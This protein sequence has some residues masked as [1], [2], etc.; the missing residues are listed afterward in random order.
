[1]LKPQRCDV[2]LGLV[3]LEIFQ[4]STI[5]NKGRYL[6]VKNISWVYAELHKQWSVLIFDFTVLVHDM[7]VAHLDLAIYD[8][9]L[10]FTYVFLCLVI[11]AHFILV[12]K[13]TL[14]AGFTT[15]NQE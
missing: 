2:F 12:T 13:L 1:M 5:V 9:L 4:F 7:S 10:V 3:L 15:R 8:F 6:Q 11:Q 14:L